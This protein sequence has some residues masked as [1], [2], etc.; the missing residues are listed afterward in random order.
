MRRVQ[1]IA[2]ACVAFAGSL[3]GFLIARPGCSGREPLGTQAK[4]SV[5]YSGTIDDRGAND[6]ALKQAEDGRSMG[7]SSR[8][9][10]ENRLAAYRSV[11]NVFSEESQ[12]A[13]FQRCIELAC[14][15]SLAAQEQVLSSLG[16]L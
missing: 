7:S 11:L 15:H 14:K 8:T 1:G 3:T 13:A 5:V 10:V 6:R 9:Q 4:P 2:L 16:A 12:H